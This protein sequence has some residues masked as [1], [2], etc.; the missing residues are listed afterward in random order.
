MNSLFSTSIVS[1]NDI[2]LKSFVVVRLIRF[3]RSPPSTLPLQLVCAPTTCPYVASHPR[4]TGPNQPLQPS[5]RASGIL[6]LVA[7]YALADENNVFT[8]VHCFA[9]D[10]AAYP[11]FIINS[12]SIILLLLLLYSDGVSPCPFIGVT[13]YNNDRWSSSCSGRPLRRRFTVTPCDER[14]LKTSRHGKETWATGA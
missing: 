5:V 12:I 9:S 1:W 7:I 4:E 13:R 2:L 11:K 3:N 6:Y 8:G 14:S 10:H